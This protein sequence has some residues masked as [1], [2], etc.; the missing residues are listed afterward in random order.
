VCRSPAL[1]DSLEGSSRCR[2][3]TVWQPPDS[4]RNAGATNKIK[5]E[6]E[7]GAGISAH[8][9]KTAGTKAKPQGA[10]KQY[11][12]FHLLFQLS[13]S[14][15]STSEELVELVRKSSMDHRG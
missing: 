9:V 7:T 11:P 6:V 2:E 5:R 15:V 14:N 8:C 4:F 13:F 3:T 10:A 1:P 12:A